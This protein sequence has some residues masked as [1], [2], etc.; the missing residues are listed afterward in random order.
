V[1]DLMNAIVRYEPLPA[2]D[3]RSLVDAQIPKPVAAGHDVLVRVEAV[4]VNP[5]DVK[6]RSGGQPT[7]EGRVLGYDGAG[8]VVESGP[9]VT[10]FKPGDQ[11]WWAG[12]MDRPG[13]DA[14]FELVDE[15][16]VGRKPDT[17]DWAQAAAMPLTTITA[18]ETLFDRL[19]LNE[20]SQGALYVAGATGGV[21]SMVLQ[22]A[23]A[24]LPQVTT[25]AT[26]STPDG[27]TWV[28]SLG[29]DAIVNYRGDLAAQLPDASVDWIFTSHSRGQVELYA[30]V[31]KPFGHIV[32]IDDEHGQDLYPL[33]P[34]SIA[35]HWELMF[36]RPQLRTPD[37]IGQHELLNAVAD[38]V[39]A[40]RVRSTLTE[41]MTGFDAA[42]LRRAHAAVETGATIGKVVVTR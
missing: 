6:A 5:A 2:T 1:T 18:W 30:R 10:L 3:P 26:S 28:R 27:D 32:A 14:D 41:R 8:T 11:V 13:S 29:A 25:L 9:D 21:G 38:L 12:Q 35:W 42:T 23:K 4:S 39:D 40:G 19:R 33:K 17:L 15:R 31:L 24:L 36:T 34:K 37:M 22:L 20:K 16:I 7:P